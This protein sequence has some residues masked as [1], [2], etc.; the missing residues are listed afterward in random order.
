MSIRWTAV[1]IMTGI[2]MVFMIR[3]EGSSWRNALLE[4]VEEKTFVVAEAVDLQRKPTTTPL[5]PIERIDTTTTV[6]EKVV[7][8]F[9]SDSTSYTKSSISGSTTSKTSTSS[10]STTDMRLDESFEAATS[11]C[12]AADT[13]MVAINMIKLD[14]AKVEAVKTNKISKEAKPFCQ[15]AHGSVARGR[16]RIVGFVSVDLLITFGTDHFYATIHTVE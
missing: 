11:R 13:D 1:A 12:K 7:K 10:T 16:G 14:D 3:S 5:I 6:S 2:I 15:C 4:N 9:I 8:A